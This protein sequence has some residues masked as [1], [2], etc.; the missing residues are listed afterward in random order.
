MAKLWPIGAPAMAGLF[1]GVGF[2][3]GKPRT[4]GDVAKEVAGEENSGEKTEAKEEQKEV[5]WTEKF[6]IFVF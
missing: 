3:Q 4:Q 1:T 2:G 5:F 6:E